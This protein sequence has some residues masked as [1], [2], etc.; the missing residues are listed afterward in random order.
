MSDVTMSREAM[1]LEIESLK[2]AIADAKSKMRR[3]VTIK[4]SP[5]GALSFYGFGR[6]PLTIYAKNIQE[7]FERKVE[8]E[9]FIEDHREKLSWGKEKVANG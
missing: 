1:A 2:A 7:I 5:K 8:I 9:K 6:F 4:V 3:T